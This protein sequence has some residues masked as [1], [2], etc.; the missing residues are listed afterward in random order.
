LGAILNLETS[1]K[2]RMV[3]LVGDLECD[4]L[5]PS[6]IY[7]VGVLDYDTDIFRAYTG[8]AVSEGLMRLAEA[9]IV[10]GHNFKGY[11]AKHI[12]ILTEGI[13]DIPN[14]KII[15]TLDLSRAAYPEWKS[16]KLETWGLFLGYPKIYFKDFSKFDPKMVPYCQQDC[17]ITKKVF[18]HT[19]NL[20]L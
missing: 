15:D 19:A 7:V 10:I 6:T 14:D 4:S 18:D 16:H 20:I 13:I 2:G 1:P 8:D 11:D 9:D 17:V 3:T 12:R 5:K